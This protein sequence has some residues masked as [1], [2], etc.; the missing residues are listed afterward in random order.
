MSC[1]IPELFKIGSINFLFFPFNQFMNSK[2]KNNNEKVELQ[3][4][5]SSYDSDT[6]AN[7]HINSSHQNVSRNVSETLKD[8]F[9]DYN[10]S[11]SIFFRFYI[12]QFRHQTTGS[13]SQKC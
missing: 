7:F 4:E 5:D 2:N 13:V 8:E 1:A 10:S 12:F 9:E 6:E 11:V 3:D